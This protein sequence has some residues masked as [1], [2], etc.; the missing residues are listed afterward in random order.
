MNGTT[1]YHEDLFDSSSPAIT[2]A[3]TTRFAKT[4][5]SKQ[6]Q[7]G[8]LM[9]HKRDAAPVHVFRLSNRKCASDSSQQCQLDEDGDHPEGKAIPQE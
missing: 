5:Q 3:E 9:A 4:E 6:A 1:R 8:S 2:M 7:C